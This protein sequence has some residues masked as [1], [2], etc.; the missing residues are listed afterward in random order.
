MQ[1]MS[2]RTRPSRT[3]LTIT[4]GHTAPFKKR[5]NRRKRNW[6]RTW[7]QVALCLFLAEA[8]VLLFANPAL[9][10][11]QVRVEGVQTLT[12][13]QVF[14]E[15]QVPSRTNIF[16]MLRQPFA[17]RLEADPAIDRVTR[18]IKLP[19]TL[20]LTVTERQPRA[21][22]A[23]GGQFW[24]LDKKGVPYRELDVPL[25]HLPVVQVAQAVLPTEITLGKPLR[26]AWL[27]DAYRLL[28]L[29]QKTPDLAYA[30]ITVDQNLNLCL[31]SKNNLQIRLGQPD[32]L[33]QKVALAAATV[34]ADGGALAKQAVYIDVSSLRQPVYMPRKDSELDNS[35]DNSQNTPADGNTSGIT[36]NEHDRTQ[37]RID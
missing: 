24:L 16:W 12:S 13:K 23:G 26:T 25:P 11:T 6:N 31:N 4:E 5:T 33:P 37:S 14:E 19:H 22:L 32:S 20:V 18:S 10:V 8:G 29:L 28:A 35:Q 21:V 1:K 17:Q 27:P 7:K 2:K 36:Q 9:R 15:A 30:K 3:P 34:N